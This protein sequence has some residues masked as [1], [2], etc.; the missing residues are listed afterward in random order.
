VKIGG[1]AID[2][3]IDSGATLITKENAPKPLNFG[4]SIK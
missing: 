4:N 3:R 2:K 1:K